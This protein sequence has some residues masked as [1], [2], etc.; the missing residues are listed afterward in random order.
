MSF[1]NNQGLTDRL[2]AAAKARS[3]MLARFRA[4]P[5]ADDPAVI[6]REAERRA[7]IEAREVRA[8]ERAEQQRIARER[9]EAEAEAERKATEERLLAERL[10]AEEQ[11]VAR[12]AELKAQRDARYLARKDKAKAKAQRR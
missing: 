7:I 10:A 5:A 9:A 6:A 12:Q 1:H 4:R 2:D 3:D 11:A 8:A